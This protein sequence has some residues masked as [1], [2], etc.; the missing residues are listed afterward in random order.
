MSRYF[1]RPAAAKPVYIETPLWGD[2]EPHRPHLS[3]DEHEPSFTGLLD[4]KGEEIWKAPNEMG[5]HAK[6]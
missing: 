1:T 3:V 6:L 4:H 2:E 5:F